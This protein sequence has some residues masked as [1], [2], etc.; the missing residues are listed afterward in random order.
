MKKNKKYQCYYCG[1]HHSKVE[2]QGIFYCPNNLCS[3]PGAAYFRSTLK[4]YTEDGSG[5]YVHPTERMVKGFLKNLTTRIFYFR[6]RKPDEA[7]H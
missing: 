6:S 3:G 4:S 5:H 2:A 1:I 7:N